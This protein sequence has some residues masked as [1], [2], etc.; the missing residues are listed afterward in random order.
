VAVA[1]I[2]ADLLNDADAARLHVN[3]HRIPPS[4]IYTK[5]ITGSTNFQTLDEV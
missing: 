2:P 4:K 5:E 3:G 1:G